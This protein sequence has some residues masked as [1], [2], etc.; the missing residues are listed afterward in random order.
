MNHKFQSDLTK[1]HH[2]VDYFVY[3]LCELSYTLLIWQLCRFKFSIILQAEG[4]D[5]PLNTI[6]FV[7]TLSSISLQ[8]NSSHLQNHELQLHF[9]FCKCD[10]T[11]RLS[12][13]KHSQIIFKNLLPLNAYLNPLHSPSKHLQMHLFLTT[14]KPQ[15][16]S[17]CVIE[18]LG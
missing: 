1:V 18:L 5:M 6:N 13:Q 15:I 7:I 2:N 17:G 4:F 3:E 10:C 12:E 11:P 8:L 9:N 14:L 16:H